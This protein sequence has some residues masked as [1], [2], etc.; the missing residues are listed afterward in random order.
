MTDSEVDEVLRDLG[1]D[2]ENITDVV[3]V[4]N[5]REAAVDVI[6]EINNMVTN[7][8][9]E[10]EVATETNVESEDN[11]LVVVDDALARF[12]SAVWFEEVQRNTILVGGAGGISSHFIF[13]LS[14]LHPRQIFVYDDDIVESV[15]LAGQFYTTASIGKS[16]VNAVADIVQQ[17]SNYRAIMS[18]PNRFTATTEAADIMIC[19][20]DNMKARSDFFYAWL[21]K[22]NASEDKSKCLFIDGRLDVSSLQIFC[23]TGDDNYN[24]SRYIKEYLF[25]DNEA[26]ETV[27]SLKQTTYCASII[28]AMMCNLY[29]NFCANRVGA[30]YDLPFKTYYDANLLLL[31]TEA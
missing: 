4:G 5:L 30:M 27:C 19:G 31:K 28:G 12:S 16:K 7:E 24:I 1:I 21:K 22:V 6:E 18:I 23:I 17:F 14:R 13:N 26:E 9:A 20:F 11:E 15:N 29:T 25:S 10:Q 2:T 3:N 8:S